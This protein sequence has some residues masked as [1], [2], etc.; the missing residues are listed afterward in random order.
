MELHRKIQKLENGV[1]KLAKECAEYED[2]MA[3]VEKELEK[4]KRE[5]PIALNE[6]KYLS[7]SE[8]CFIPLITNNFYRNEG[9][10]SGFGTHLKNSAALQAFNNRSPTASFAGSPG[11]LNRA[12]NSDKV[13]IS[14]VSAL[15]S[16][17]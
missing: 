12:V 7:N 1:D 14:R 17:F 2:K 16:L 5:Q 4:L 13:I 11:H 6:S 8:I 15:Y 9:A 10:C 3:D